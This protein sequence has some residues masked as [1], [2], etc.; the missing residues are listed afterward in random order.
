MDIDSVDTYYSDK[1]LAPTDVVA[2][3]LPKPQR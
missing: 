1:I 2:E 3:K